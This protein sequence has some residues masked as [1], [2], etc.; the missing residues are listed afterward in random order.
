MINGLTGVGDIFLLLPREVVR[1]F[2]TLLGLFG[3]APPENDICMCVS[4]RPLRKLVPALLEPYFFL[5]CHLP[6]Y[7]LHRRRSS[8]QLC[9]VH[10]S[11]FSMGSSH[12]HTHT[13]AH[14]A[15]IFFPKLALRLLPL[16]DS[17]KKTRQ[18][19]RLIY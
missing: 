16:P 7:S 10:E 9:V 5:S 2:F 4:K 3:L 8:S 12:T 11:Q 13:Q 1:A 19:N 18:Q 6:F 17:E 14:V 15:I